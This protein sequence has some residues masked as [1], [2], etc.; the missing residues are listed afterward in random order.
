[1]CGGEV[2]ALRGQVMELLPEGFIFLGNGCELLGYP[3]Q[4][5]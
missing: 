2:G 3:T 5:M 4:L 1:M